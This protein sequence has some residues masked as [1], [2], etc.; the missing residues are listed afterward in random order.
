M[1]PCKPFVKNGNIIDEIAKSRDMTSVIKLA[2]AR[3]TL[4]IVDVIEMFGKH[5]HKIERATAQKVWLCLPVASVATGWSRMDVLEETARVGKEG[6]RRL[7]IMCG[8][9]G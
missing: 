6:I 5:G 3:D 8:Y 9:G 1:L 4:K 7:Y 2:E